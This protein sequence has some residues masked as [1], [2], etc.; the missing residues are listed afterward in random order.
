MTDTQTLL[1]SFEPL[2]NPRSVAVVGASNV[3]GKWGFIVP[4]NLVLGGYRGKLYFVNPTETSVHGYRAKKNLEE[5]RGNSPDGDRPG[6]FADVVEDVHSE[7][8]FATLKL[9]EMKQIVADTIVIHLLTELPAQL[10]KLLGR[11]LRKG[12]RYVG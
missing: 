1:E 12:L 3:P 4:L 8:P 6:N 10:C 7:N 5:I 9:G 2:F 11:T